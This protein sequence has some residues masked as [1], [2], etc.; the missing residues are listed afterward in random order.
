MFL[1]IV[2]FVQIPYE[3]LVIILKQTFKM[4]LKLFNSSLRSQEMIENDLSHVVAYAP[5]VTTC[6]KVVTTPGISLGFYKTLSQF[7]GSAFLYLSNDLFRWWRRFV[8]FTAMTS[9]NEVIVIFLQLILFANTAA[10]F[11]S[12]LGLVSPAFWECDSREEIST[13][14]CSY[15]ETIYHTRF[16]SCSKKRFC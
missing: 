1:S 6:L 5:K 3:M 11:C 12:L 2:C 14:W 9:V 7:F 8:V 4:K 13:R 10:F 15:V 16:L